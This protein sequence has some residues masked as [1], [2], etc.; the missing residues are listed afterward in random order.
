MEDSEATQAFLNA[1]QNYSVLATQ[2]TNLFKCF[3]PQAWMIGSE[4]GVSGFLHPENIYDDPKG[5]ALRRAV[6]SRL[7]AHFQ[8]VNEME[9]FADND[10]R[11]LLSVNICGEEHAEHSS[12]TSPISTH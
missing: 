10:H 3:L 2:Q 8:F 4:N 6:H 1:M 11:T 5:G 9:L 12:I 7:R